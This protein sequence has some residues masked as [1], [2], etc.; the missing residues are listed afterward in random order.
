MS[1]FDPD[2]GLIPSIYTKWRADWN[3]P[4]NQAVALVKQAHARIIEAENAIEEQTVNRRSNGTP[5]GALSASNRDPLRRW[6]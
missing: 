2:Q 6:D 3:A 4:K 5:F 1:D